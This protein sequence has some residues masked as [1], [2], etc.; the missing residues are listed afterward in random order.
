MNPM[1]ATTNTERDL[2][3]SIY[4]SSCFSLDRQ[5]RNNAAEGRMNDKNNVGCI[6]QSGISTQFSLSKRA[7]IIMVIHQMRETAA[8]HQPVF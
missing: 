5:T 2:M 7:R 3:Y 1:I 6:I 8:S 4:S